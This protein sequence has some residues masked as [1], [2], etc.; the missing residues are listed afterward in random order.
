MWLIP[1]RLCSSN[2]NKIQS[3]PEWEKGGGGRREEI[4]SRESREK[5]SLPYLYVDFQS[6]EA[7]RKSLVGVR[8]PPLCD[9]SNC[10]GDSTIQV[11]DNIRVCFN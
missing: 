3:N 5:G 6:S 8:A 1:S 10:F 7:G 9:E 11:W 4:E 2:N